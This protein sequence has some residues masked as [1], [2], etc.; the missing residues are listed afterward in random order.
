MAKVKIVAGQKSRA[1]RYKQVGLN[2]TVGKTVEAIGETT[3]PS[4]NG[5]EPCIVLFFTDG[6]R[7]GFVLPSDNW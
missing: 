6:S 1:G 5:D 4:N 2:E 7:H 3:V